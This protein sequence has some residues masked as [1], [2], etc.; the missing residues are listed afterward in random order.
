MVHHISR[1]PTAWTSFAFHPFE[2]LIQALFIPVMVFILPI[3]VTVLGLHL[4]L[5][6]V[7]GVTNHLGREIYPSWIEKKFYLITAT[8]HQKHHQSMSVNYGLYFTWWDLLFQTEQKDK[9]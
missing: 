9:Q 2:A 6:S 4:L 7:F 3:H 8:H 1:N 5:M